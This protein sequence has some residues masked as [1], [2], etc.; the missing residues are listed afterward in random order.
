MDDLSA[1]EVIGI[2]VGVVLMFIFAK[3]T[4][5]NCNCD[6]YDRSRKSDDLD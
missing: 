4:S 5:E 6:E 1:A 3:G 2:V